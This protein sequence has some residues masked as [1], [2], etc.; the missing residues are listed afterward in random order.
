MQNVFDHN[1]CRIFEDDEVL[2]H[3]VRLS[4]M[5]GDK[6]EIF[7]YVKV[8][9]DG[10]GLHDIGKTKHRPSDRDEGKLMASYSKIIQSIS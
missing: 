8:G 3:V 2:D 10:T 7:Q 1:A 4:E 5:N 6:L 9:F